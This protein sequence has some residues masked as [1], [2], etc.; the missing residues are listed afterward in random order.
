M[1]ISGWKSKSRQPRVASVWQ[2]ES[3]VENVSEIVA[4]LAKQFVNKPAVDICYM[5]MVERV[6]NVAKYILGKLQLINVFCNHGNHYRRQE[7]TWKI[8]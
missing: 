6:G 8:S 5:A 1:K 3:K 4:K 7:K 2:N